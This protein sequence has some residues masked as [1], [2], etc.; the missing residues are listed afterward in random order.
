MQSIL[1][2]TIQALI[3]SHKATFSHKAYCFLKKQLCEKEGGFNTFEGCYIKLDEIAHAVRMD[4]NMSYEHKRIYLA[5]I[6]TV[7][8]KLLAHQHGIV[9]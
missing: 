9:A 2:S 3:D 4:K 8:D 6:N 1:V 5:C 7:T